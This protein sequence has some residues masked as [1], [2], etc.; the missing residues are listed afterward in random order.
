AT[1]VAVPAMPA[2]ARDAK[3]AATSAADGAPDAKDATLAQLV[4]GDGAKADAGADGLAQLKAKAAPA[5]QAALQA[6]GERPA[7]DTAIPVTVAK[8]TP[9]E[10]AA[11]LKAATPAAQAAPATPIAPAAVAGLEVAKAAAAAV[12]AERLPARV[13]TPG[14]DQQ[15]GQKIVFMAAG[16]EQSATMELNP[17][18][19]GPLQVVLNV[20]NDHATV[21]F[22]SAQPEVRQALEAAVP[23]LREMM[24]DAGIQLGNATVSAGM[25]NQD[26]NFQQQAA[27]T[28]SGNGGGGGGHGGARFGR[29]SAEPAPRSAPP[30]RRLPAGAVDTF[31]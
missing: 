20:S 9:A 21:A 28:Q 15:L 16:G 27:S 10:A 12:P 3:A 13:G 25:S 6:G 1:A 22:S 26:N 2:A 19:L 17:P 8:A 11:V 30:V 14:W 4:G 23:K 29:D 5:D 7:P 18:D 31:A 24:S